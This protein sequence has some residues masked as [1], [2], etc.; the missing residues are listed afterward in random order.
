[1]NTSDTYIKK[2]HRYG[3]TTKP[4][5]CLPWAFERPISVAWPGVTSRQVTG[6]VRA[7]PRAR[8]EL[9]RSDSK[10]SRGGCRCR[11]EK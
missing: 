9:T 11:P 8:T 6:E 4:Q 7:G 5:F 3:E 2:P 10:Q 1:M